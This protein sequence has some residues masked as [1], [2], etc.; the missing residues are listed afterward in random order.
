MGRVFVFDDEITPNLENLPAFIDKLVETTM[1]YYAPQVANY[2]KS[3]A[4]W[5]DQTSNARNGLTAQAG[6][7]GD[8][9]FI[10][11]AHRVDYGIYL[12]T[13]WGGRYAIINE[14][15][16]AMMGPIMQTLNGSLDRYSGG[17]G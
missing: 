10:T 4:P 2:A 6:R 16:Q 11:L 14:T 3:N 12:E 7:D 13:R 9:H 8:T 15:I 17:I 1:S 5:T